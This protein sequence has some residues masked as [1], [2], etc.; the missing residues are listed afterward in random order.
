MKH[1]SCELILITKHVTQCENWYLMQDANIEKLRCLIQGHLVQVE[2]NIQ[3][4]IVK[5]VIIINLCALS[6]IVPLCFQ[7]FEYSNSY[8]FSN[9]KQKQTWPV[10]INN[11]TYP[12]AL[13]CLWGH[14][15]IISCLLICYTYNDFNQTSVG[16][17]TFINGNDVNVFQKVGNA[18]SVNDIVQC[19]T[20]DPFCAIMSSLQAYWWH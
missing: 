19:L 20:S 17:I 6:S 1:P 10:Q 3:M 9:L 7:S 2:G 15:Y 11:P 8:D 13:C 18:G 4:I 5:K 14:R 12:L 16:Y